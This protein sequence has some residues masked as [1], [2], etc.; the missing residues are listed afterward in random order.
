ME[1]QRIHRRVR[2]VP[3]LN[4][5]ECRIGRDNDPEHQARI[6]AHQERIQAELPNHPEGKER[7][8]YIE[9][10]ED[11]LRVAA[12][13]AE[14]GGA[15]SNWS[16]RCDLGWDLLRMRR[17]GR[18]RKW[19]TSQYACLHLTDAGRDAIKPET[20][21]NMLNTA[22]LEVID[23]LCPGNHLARD[24]LRRRILLA[25]AAAGGALPLQDLALCTGESELL[26]STICQDWLQV[27]PTRIGADQK[28]G[29]RLSVLLLEKLGLDPILGPDHFTD[30]RSWLAR[31]KNISTV[32]E[33]LGG[34]PRDRYVPSP[35]VETRDCSGIAEIR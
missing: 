29:Y 33:G 24:V 19:F 35:E 20:G 14:H 13:L 22:Q 11:R 34:L 12:Y 17:V 8:I 5:H 28:H 23:Q 25:L 31:A 26:L 15:A 21:G 30:I 3:C 6:L 9:A 4:L 7:R 18:Y 2:D 27:M 10:R 32:E 1:E 16:I